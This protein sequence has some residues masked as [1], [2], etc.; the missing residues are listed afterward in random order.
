MVDYASNTHKSK[1]K[2]DIPEKTV[3]VVVETP[4][5]IK[6]KT[7][8]EEIADLF[9]PEDRPSIKDYIIKDVFVPTIKRAIVSSVDLFFNGTTTVA[10]T[11]RT[12][13][14]PASRIAYNSISTKQTKVSSLATTRT[15][16]YGTLIFNTRAEAEAVLEQIQEIIDV[17]N[18]ASVNDLFDSAGLTGDATSTK[19]GWTSIE[20]ARVEVTDGGYSIRMPKARPI[21]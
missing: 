9:L 1:E 10:P 5:R 6:K 21:N 20:G 2:N 18:I 11:T 15:Y 12:T 14:T 17:Y 3:E 16:D 7:M 13:T 19:W 8:L 4:P